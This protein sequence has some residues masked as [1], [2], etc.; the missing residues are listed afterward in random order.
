M[1]E[2]P[3]STA[4]SAPSVTEPRTPAWL[5]L[6]AVVSGF[7]NLLPFLLIFSIPATLVLLVVVTTQPRDPGR[8]RAMTCLVAGLVVAA[9]WLLLLLPV[10]TEVVG[11]AHPVPAA[12]PEAG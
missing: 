3:S 9:V 10:T 1:G 12:E 4:P 7:A 5:V 8:R 6:L 11:E 2:A